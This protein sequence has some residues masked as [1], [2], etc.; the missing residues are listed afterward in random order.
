MDSTGV[1]KSGPV[2]A[3]LGMK[4]RWGGLAELLVC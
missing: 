1:L 4:G 3:L 2:A